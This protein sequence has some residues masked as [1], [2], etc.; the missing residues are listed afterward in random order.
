MIPRRYLLAVAS[1]L[2]VPF[3]ASA[4]VTLGTASAFG[5]LGSAAI[6]NTGPTSITG[7]IGVSDSGSITGFPPGAFTGIEHL[8]DAT[9]IQANIDAMCCSLFS[10]G[11]C[12]GFG[13]VFCNDM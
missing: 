9:T 6:T 8:N 13:S 10:S 1:C 11:W 4:Q 5:V 2:A 3:I 12:R 7:D